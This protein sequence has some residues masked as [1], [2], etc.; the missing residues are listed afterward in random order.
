MRGEN[1]VVAG[2]LGFFKGSGNVAS[3]GFLSATRAAAL[4][5]Q[6]CAP[7]ETRLPCGKADN[8]GNCER[9][10]LLFGKCYEVRPDHALR[11]A[12]P[13]GLRPGQPRALDAHLRPPGR[14]R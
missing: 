3:A 14:P 11:L 10:D 9:Y 7:P 13:G 8:V 2:P 5:A 1:R 4:T 12:L 6:I